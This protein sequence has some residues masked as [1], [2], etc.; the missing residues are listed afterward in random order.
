VIIAVATDLLPDVSDM[1]DIPDFNGPAWCEVSGWNLKSYESNPEVIHSGS[2][3][4]IYRATI[5]AN[6]RTV[7]L[8]RVRVDADVKKMVR[9]VALLVKLRHPNIVSIEKCFEQIDDTTGRIHWLYCQMPFYEGGNLKDWL[10]KVREDLR[11]H[12]S[13][14][15]QLQRA[16]LLYDVLV[17]ADRVHTVTNGGAHKDIKLSVR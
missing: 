1:F 13:E 4:T 8:K 2:R 7:C 15:L 3:N 6:N 17:A 14:G 9:D 5:R 12:N 16:S 11:V 10:L